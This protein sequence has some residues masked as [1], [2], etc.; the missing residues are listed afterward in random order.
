MVKD[1]NE[2]KKIIDALD[3]G[4]HKCYEE[5]KT[6]EGKCYGLSGGDSNTCFLNYACVG[7]KYLTM[8]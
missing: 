1:E 5:H 3:I 7:C 8:L 2:F 6:K 4:H